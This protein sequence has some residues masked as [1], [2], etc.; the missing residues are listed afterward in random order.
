MFLAFKHFVWVYA[1]YFTFHYC[2]LLVDTLKLNVNYYSNHFG[3]ISQ[4]IIHLSFI[5][6]IDI[7]YR[8]MN[9]YYNN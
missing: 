2:Y 3:I 1:A 9:Y 4:P 7:D 6:P 5:D 8:F